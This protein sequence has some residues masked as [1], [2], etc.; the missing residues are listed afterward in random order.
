MSTVIGKINKLRH[1][2]V[3]GG[4]ILFLFVFTAAFSPF[5][6]P[7]DPVSQDL[8]QTLLPPA[9]ETGGSPEFLLGTDNMGRD[10]LSRLIHGARVSLV[11]GVASVALALILG[12]ALG[13]LAGYLGG[14]VENL[15][16]RLTDMQLAMPF[17]L[18]A[19]AIIGALG[20]STKNIIIVLAVCNW[21]T[22]ARLVRSEVLSV[23]HEE[24]VELAVVDG[25]SMP[26][27]LFFHILP[28]VVNTIIVMATL[29]MGRM[30]IFEGALSFL[31]LGVQPPSPTWGG[32]L[33]DGRAYLSV[34]WQLATFPGVA[35]MLVV[36]GTNLFGDWLRD[37][38]D[39][40]RKRKMQGA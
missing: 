18:M 10:V 5:I 15:I 6:A 16:M 8:R 40:K 11:V 1:F 26:R 17:I 37:I 24:F 31:G 9:W 20:P 28:N 4:L 27:I 12:T 36:L 32:M 34:S 35:I 19:I 38:L 22:Y 2:P 33:A 13:L 39:P 29:D 25:C 30:I 3:A 21:A 14:W 23:K 7:H